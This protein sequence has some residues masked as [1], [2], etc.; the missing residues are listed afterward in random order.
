MNCVSI[1]RNG[2]TI[3]NIHSAIWWT[4]LGRRLCQGAVVAVG[5]TKWLLLTEI[6]IVSVETTTV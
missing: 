5:M 4:K 2:L 6:A 1:E 3:D